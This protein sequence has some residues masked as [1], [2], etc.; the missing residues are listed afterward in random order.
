MVRSTFKMSFFS[1]FSSSRMATPSAAISAARGWFSKNESASSASFAD[2]TVTTSPFSVTDVA[3]PSRE[4]NGFSF[5][6]DIF[7]PS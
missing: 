2:S 3:R 6:F 1:R 4:A 7:S 5:S